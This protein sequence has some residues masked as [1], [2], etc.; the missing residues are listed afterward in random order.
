VTADRGGADV[1]LVTLWA[2]WG[3]AWV[4]RVKPS[5]QLCRAGVWPKLQ[6]L[7]VPGQTRG[8]LL[9]PGRYGAEAPKALGGTLRRKRARHGKRGLWYGVAHRP[10]PGAQAV[11]AYARWPG[12]EAGFRAAT[13]WLGVAPARLKPIT[14][15]SR[16][17]A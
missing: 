11:A 10:Y 6:T 15:W 7:R 9:G 1:T 16:L 12:C 13:W 5:S 8:R 14:A 2:E 4:L 17:F 3:L